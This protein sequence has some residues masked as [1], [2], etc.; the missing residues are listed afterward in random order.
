MSY[1]F[2]FLVSIS[3]TRGRRKAKG[4]RRACR[5]RGSRPQRRLRH[6]GDPLHPSSAAFAGSPLGLL[7]MSDGA[8]AT[9]VLLVG[10]AGLEP[11]T[12]GL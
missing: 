9:E 6:V 7:D 8:A 12:E 4:S 1:A 2:S 3:P 5:G 10:W 11:A